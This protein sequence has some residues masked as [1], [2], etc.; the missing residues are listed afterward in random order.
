ME[1]NLRRNISR[2]YSLLTDQLRGAESRSVTED[3]FHPRYNRGEADGYRFALN[4]LRQEPVDSIVGILKA[5]KDHA[6]I[7]MVYAQGESVADA[8]FYDGM[9]TA[10]DHAWRNASQFFPRPVLQPR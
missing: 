5:Q 8:E 2:F 10:L 7:Y 6:E 4:T 1:K 3:I 9:Y